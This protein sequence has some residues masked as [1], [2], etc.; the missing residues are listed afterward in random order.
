ARSGGN[1]A[2]SSS[3]SEQELVSAPVR[4]LL[5]EGSRNYSGETRAI[6]TAALARLIDYQD[7]AYAREFLARLDRIQ[8][9]EDAHGDASRRLLPET[10][11]QLALPIAYEDTIRVADLKIRNSRFARLRE[12]VQVQP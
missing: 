10:A 8:E 12:E 5:D 11:R 9:I 1:G 2:A 6:I 4:E 3:V 7:A